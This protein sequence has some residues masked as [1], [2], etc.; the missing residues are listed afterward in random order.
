[1]KR[2]VVLISLDTL[3]Y[4]CVG[5]CPDKVHLEAYGL[6]RKL[7][8]PNL[9]AFFNEGLYFAQ[10][11]TPAPYTTAAHA[12]VMTGLYAN[13]HGVRPF[14]KWGLADGVGTLAEEL[15][16]RGYVTVAVQERGEETALKTGSGVLRGFDR[17]FGDEV[18]ACAYCAS[19]SGP[20]LLFIHTF[21][22]HSP[23]C[24]SH[25]DAV[26]REDADR[27]DAERW[28]VRRLGIAPPRDDGIEEQNRFMFRTSQASRRVLDGR[29]ASRL[30]LEWYVRGVNWF[31]RVRWPR[32]VRALKDAG[33]YGNSLVVVFA[34]HGEAALP[35][36]DFLPLT[37]MDSMLEDVLR[38][39]LVLHGPEL[40]G[41]TV[42]DAASL[43]DVAPAVMDYLGLKA[44][45]VGRAGRTDGQSLLGLDGDA[46]RGRRP[47]FAETWR[48]WSPMG[49]DDRGGDAWWRGQIDDPC[50]PY[51]VC[52]R[53]GDLKLLWHPGA[54]RVWRF[55]RP[56]A[57]A[58]ARLLSAR[59]AALYGL[60]RLRPLLRRLMP[61]AVRAAAGSL[62][63][64]LR[65]AV[66]YRGRRGAVGQLVGRDPLAWRDAPWFAFDLRADPL[67]E[68]PT[69][70]GS[71]VPPGPWADLAAGV[72]QYWED[73]VRGPLIE[74]PQADGAKVMQH[75][76]NLGY[77]D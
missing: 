61:H 35:D 49:Q 59:R 65:R 63:S 36:C 19:Q 38:V 22:I 1:M 12:S 46:A 57:R 56:A 34:D 69:H 23:Y 40:K 73:G 17:F 77:V 11:R 44:S 18:D 20:C 64:S 14:Y 24:W 21:D 58:L 70:L 29:G 54:P 10:A 37:H 3:R 45:V 76:R 27:K 62:E 13:H 51:Q 60:D 16:D 72:R 55:M 33:L 39:P 71:A 68:R 48:T 5:A 25:V 50:E 41:R 75:L 4:D 9:D 8:T 2:S 66:R 30:F 67:E 32:I 15:R 53:S 43:I 7:S 42:S 52:V 31:D 28:I 6:G 74:L 26:C 47:H